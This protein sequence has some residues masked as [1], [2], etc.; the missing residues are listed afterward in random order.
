MNLEEVMITLSASENP[1]E[2]LD[3]ITEKIRNLPLALYIEDGGIV[4]SV[5]AKFAE[6]GS[7]G[8][9]IVIEPMLHRRAQEISFAVTDNN[10]CVKFKKMTPE[11]VKLIHDENVFFVFLKTEGN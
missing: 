1:R 7:D 10:S 5:K 8:R 6:V 2:E 4:L 9:G 11:Y 3:K